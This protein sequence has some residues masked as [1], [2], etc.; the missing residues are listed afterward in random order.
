MGFEVLVEEWEITE[1]ING[2]TSKTEYRRDVWV[3]LDSNNKLPRLANANIVY[4]S[5]TETKI[6]KIK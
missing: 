3:E 4:S 1:R 6:R 5:K 2:E